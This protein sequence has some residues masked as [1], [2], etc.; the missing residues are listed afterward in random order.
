[1]LFEVSVRMRCVYKRLRRLRERRS[2]VKRA[3]SAASGAEERL[4]SCCGG[5]EKTGPKEDLEKV[6]ESADIGF[7]K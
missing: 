3:P 5:L 4:E 6:N 1:M 2:K 7:V